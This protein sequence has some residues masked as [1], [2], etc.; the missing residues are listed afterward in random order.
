MFPIND[1]DRNEFEDSFRY[2][3]DIETDDYRLTEIEDIS[4]E[5]KKRFKAVA[6]LKRTTRPLFVS[7]RTS[8]TITSD[9]NYFTI[10]CLTY[11]KIVRITF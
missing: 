6:Y 11:H 2:Y 7:T 4:L 1:E 5:D 9:K 3:P 8:P 10:V